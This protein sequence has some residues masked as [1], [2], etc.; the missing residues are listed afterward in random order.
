MISLSTPPS[1]NGLRF[2][3]S[4]DHLVTRSM[5]KLEERSQ[6]RQTGPYGPIGTY[7]DWHWGGTSLNSTREKDERI[8]FIFLA[9]RTE[10]RP[11]VE[12]GAEDEEQCLVRGDW[13]VAKYV[14]IDNLVPGTTLNDSWKAR[15][16]DHRAVLVELEAGS[17]TM[18]TLST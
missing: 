8:D 5:K 17:E 7:T 11:G 14:V 6:W 13:E 16:S 3:D 10:I 4:R 18:M 12:I 15:W 1:S 2:I 9:T